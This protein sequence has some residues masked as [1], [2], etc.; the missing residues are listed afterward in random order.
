MDTSEVTLLP[1]SHPAPRALIAQF[2]MSSGSDH[3]RSQKDPSWGIST[4]LSIRFI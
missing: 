4:L 1:K 3:I 2:S